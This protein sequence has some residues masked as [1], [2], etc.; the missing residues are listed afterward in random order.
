M[1]T[2][3]QVK[4]RGQIVGQGTLEVLQ[5]Q[6][7]TGQ[8]TPLH[9][10]C[11]DDGVWRYAGDFPELFPAS[12]TGS[13]AANSPTPAP[14]APA[15][16][17]QW[18]VSSGDEPLGPYTLRQVIDLIAGGN[19]SLAE[20]VWQEGTPEWLPIPTAFPRETA[21][22]EER[23][24]KTERRRQKAATKEA[25]REEVRR[26]HAAIPPEE[27]SYSML[28][29]ASIVFSAF[30]IF[31]AGSLMGV[32]LGGIAAY[33]IVESDGR[34]RGM[35]SAVAGISLGV[36]GLFIALVVFGNRL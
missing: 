28:A 3:Y 13:T 35:R 12:A 11:G 15:A 30:W 1:S 27:K 17:P 4:L 25:K 14:A 16:E 24:A 2:N 32:I 26:R 31:G 8:L 9:K 36:F 22:V 21:W 19:V 7:A 5:R 10:L 20:K 34:R 23:L 18:Y 29:I 6:V 33:D